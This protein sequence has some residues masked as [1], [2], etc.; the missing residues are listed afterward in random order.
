MEILVQ[1]PHPIGPVVRRRLLGR[2]RA[3]PLALTVPGQHQVGLEV[4]VQLVLQDRLVP[5]EHLDRLAQE[6]RLGVPHLLTG[7]GA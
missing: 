2:I 3:V 5:Q 4:L 1:L 7:P 6:Q